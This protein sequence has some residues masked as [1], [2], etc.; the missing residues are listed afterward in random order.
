MPYSSLPE[1]FHFDAG[2]T[3]F[4]HARQTFRSRSAFS[5]VELLVVIA[6][7][8]VLVALMTPAFLSFS[9]S[10]GRR[11]AVNTVMNTLEQARVAALEAGRDVYVVFWRKNNTD[12]EQDA[13]GVF[14]ETEDGSGNYEQ[15]SK[16]LQLPKRILLHQPASGK[17]IFAASGNPGF[18]K[19][20][21]PASAAST[22]LDDFGIVKFSPSGTVL[23][24]VNSTENVIILTE[25]ERTDGSDSKIDRGGLFEIISI[26]K[27]TG[28]PT[29]E[30]TSIPSS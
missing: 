11:G 8:S 26:A 6:I 7:F 13:I 17:N 18:D 4:K 5:M 27:Y 3:F 12:T 2:S 24:P 20:R 28:R 30:V 25:G 15:L 16:W 14:R 21:I 29:L 19:T 23:F 1:I 9:G 10:A 22:G